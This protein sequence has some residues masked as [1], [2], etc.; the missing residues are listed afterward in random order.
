MTRKVGASIE[1]YLEGIYR[2]QEKNG[3]ATTSEIIKLLNVV[4]G[5]ITN[6]M[7]RLKREGLTYK[8]NSGKR[9]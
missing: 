2:L 5:T 9:E 7:K 4:P 1:R 6:T 8:T 3:I